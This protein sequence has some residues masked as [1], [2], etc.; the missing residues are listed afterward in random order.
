MF[1]VFY[2]PFYTTKNKAL[3]WGAMEFAGATSKVLKK[4]SLNVIE[5]QKCN[6]TYGNVNNGKIC[7]FTQGEKIK[8]DLF[9]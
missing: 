8:F 4:T 6:E 2:F 3:G 1:Y 5:N 7:T 9:S